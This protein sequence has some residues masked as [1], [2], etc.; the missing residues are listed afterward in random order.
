MRSLLWFALLCGSAVAVAAETPLVQPGLW[1]VSID[2]EME[3]QA[4]KLPTQSMRVCMKAQE[5][6]DP[7]KMIPANPGC[8]LSEVKHSGK[9]MSWQVSCRNAHGEVRGTGHINL[10]GDRYHGHMDAFATVRGKAF[11]M[12]TLYAGK[13]LSDCR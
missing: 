2:R 12:K 8:K 5:V 4:A 1:E 9:Q 10:E 11:A 3:G 7:T 6:A 13:R